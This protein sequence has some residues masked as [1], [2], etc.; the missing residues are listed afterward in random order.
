MLGSAGAF[1][2]SGSGC[3]DS[4]VEAAGAGFAAAAGRRRAALGANF[5][6]EVFLLM[7]ELNVAG[8]CA[9]SA[10]ASGGAELSSAMVAACC[11]VQRRAAMSTLRR[12]EVY[13]SH[14][15]SRSSTV[16]PAN[17]TNHLLAPLP[18]CSFLRPR[19]LFS[20]LTLP[21][22]TRHHARCFRQLR[23]PSAL[24][25]LIHLPLMTE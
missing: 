16:G 10:C 4:A 13:E 6:P 7:K 18:T 24:T 22:L 20:S 3:C 15:Q 23:P 14:A 21:G 25:P 1:E 19:P 12:V 8:A 2:D 11:L 5:L 17:H 9:L